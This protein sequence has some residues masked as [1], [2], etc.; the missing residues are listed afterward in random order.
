MLK[1]VEITI[2]LMTLILV[3][4]LIIVIVYYS[5]QTHCMPSIPNNQFPFN[6]Y[7]ISLDRKPERYHYVK[8]EVHNVG[9]NNLQ[10]L[11]GT[12]GHVLTSAE[13]QK[14]GLTKEFSE[15]KGLAGCA[16]SHIR[17]WKEIARNKMGWTLI[18]EDDVHF[19]PKFSELFQAYWQQVPKD[20]LIVFPG[21]CGGGELV[22][23]DLGGGNG[24]G[25]KNFNFNNASTPKTNVVTTSVMCLH[26]YMISHVGAKYL[27]DHLLPLNTPV[28]IAIVEH[29]RNARGSY[30]FNGNDS[31]LLADGTYLRPHDYKNAMGS[32]CKFSGIIYQNHRE[33]GSTI[34]TMDTV[35]G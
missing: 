23:G 28:D 33:Q 17:M 35:F 16:A 4:V 7:V 8:N 18:L 2:L 1:P 24:G 14:H 3:I 30:V 32:K 9:I 27:L 20:A 34:H 31:V 10:R 11:P 15:K 19:H 26:G 21:Y 13:M 6:T 5:Q 29:F 22:D 12:D 25:N